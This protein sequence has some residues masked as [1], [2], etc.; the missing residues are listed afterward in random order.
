[1]WQT[2]KI[3]IFSTHSIISRKFAPVYRKTATSWSRTFQTHDAAGFRKVFL[4]KYFEY[5]SRCRVL[6]DLGVN[7]HELEF[8]F[9]SLT[10]RP[11][12]ERK[13]FRPIL[14]ARAQ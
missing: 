12:I 14:S 9:F 5:V 8:G 13:H 6:N 7:W 11:T 10:I 3:T 2:S 4:C 1:M